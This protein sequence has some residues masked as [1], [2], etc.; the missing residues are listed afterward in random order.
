M[1]VCQKCNGKGVIET[2]NRLADS[3][4][5]YAHDACN[6]CDG[7]GQIFEFVVCL[8]VPPYS[9]GRYSRGPIQ[10]ETKEELKKLVLEELDYCFGDKH[11]K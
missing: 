7:N 8:L 6:I 10:C 1:K 2:A 5:E 11:G 3:D 4:V 9:G